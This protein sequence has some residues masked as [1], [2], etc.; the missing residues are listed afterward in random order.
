MLQ[1][2]KKQGAG[3]FVAV[4]PDGIVQDASELDFDSD[5]DEDGAPVEVAP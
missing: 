2:L 1:F 3:K 5:D 4:R